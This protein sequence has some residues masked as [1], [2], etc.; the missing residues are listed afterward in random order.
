M[1]PVDAIGL[2]LTP[3]TVFNQKNKIFRSA[4]S[5]AQF[6][7][8]EQNEVL[9]LIADN[10]ADKVTI[11][12]SNKN[13][14]NGPLVALTEFIPAQEEDVVQVKI[15]GGNIVE[16]QEEVLLPFYGQI[17]P[18]VEG[19][20]NFDAFQKMIDIMEKNQNN[21]ENPDKIKPL[22]QEIDDFLATG[23][24]GKELAEGVNVIINKFVGEED[25]HADLVDN[26]EE[27]D[28]EEEF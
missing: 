6:A 3:G 18:P 28:D 7:S 13:P 8:I 10:L 16:K 2:A 20:V 25:L 5:L 12:P 27:E 19:E 1:N 9:G 4:K 11:R 15:I 23:S 22:F 24:K 17:D 21:L 26:E 14:Q